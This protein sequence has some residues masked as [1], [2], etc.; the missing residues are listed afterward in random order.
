MFLDLLMLHEEKK[1]IYISGHLTVLRDR[2]VVEAVVI[3]ANRVTRRPR[4]R[5]V[6]ERARHRR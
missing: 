3:R 1:K 5:R 2:K 6:E 4:A